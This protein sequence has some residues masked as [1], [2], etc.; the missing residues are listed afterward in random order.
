M[1][2]HRPM[3]GSLRNSG[4]YLHSWPRWARRMAVLALR[5]HEDSSCSISILPWG[6]FARDLADMEYPGL[7]LNHHQSYPG[8]SSK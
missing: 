5:R 1:I 6:Y 3:M 4:I 7:E 2:T 8:I